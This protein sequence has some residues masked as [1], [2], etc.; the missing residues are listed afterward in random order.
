M[1]TEAAIHGQ[2]LALIPRF[3][4]ENELETG[5][6]TVPVDHSFVN[7]KSYYLVY[8][9]KKSES[10]VLKHFRDRAFGRIEVCR[11]A[12]AHR[13]LGREMSAGRCGVAV[14]FHRF[15]LTGCDLFVE[16]E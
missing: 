15:R 1:S 3:L 2:G 4:I 5:L 13:F 11:S 7:N 12:E 16:R 9:E 8:P 6:L 14:H 10:T